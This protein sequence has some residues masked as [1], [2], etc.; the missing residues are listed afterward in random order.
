M[1]FE[2]EEQTS[3]IFR[4]RAMYLRELS[5]EAY[6]ALGV[7]EISQKPLSTSGQARTTAAMSEVV[8]RRKE[9]ACPPEWHERVIRKGPPPKVP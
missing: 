6:R 1:N 5:G 9:K 2:Q 3:K 7:G 4:R 8:S